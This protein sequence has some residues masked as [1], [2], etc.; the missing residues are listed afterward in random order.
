MILY[1]ESSALLAWVFGEPN[2]PAVVEILSKAPQVI[3]S[4]LTLVECDR[5]IQRSLGLGR[6]TESDA[7]DAM[8]D[9]NSMALTWNVLHLS[10]GVVMR[11]RQRFPHEPVRSLD[12]LHIAWALHARTTH[13][14]IVLLSLDDRI[15]RVGSALG[16]ALKPG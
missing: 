16:F 11:A 6:I 1:A 8:A 14:D 3:T 15:R 5:S 2:A 13:A 12:A 9:L 10:A 7:R 4:D